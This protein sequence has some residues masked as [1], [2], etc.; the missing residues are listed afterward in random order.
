M[1]RRALIT[2]LPVLTVL[3]LAPAAATAATVTVSATGGNDATCVPACA[4]LARAVTVAQPGDT[5]DVGPGE[6]PAATVATV[7]KPLTIIGE[8][9]GN[10]A[11]T[12]TPGGP[13]EST[14]I[15]TSTAALFS[16]S[17]GV[18]GLTIDGVL[19]PQRRRRAARSAPGSE[20]T[21]SPACESSTTRSRASAT[22]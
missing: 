5:V 19:V 14:L 16:V 18:T 8:Q 12:R 4:T 11:R 2:S 17:A 22:R 13:G 6:F 15:R 10:D 1:S 21:P 9:A 3:L 7:N 20:P